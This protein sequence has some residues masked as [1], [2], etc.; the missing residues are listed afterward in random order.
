ME[1]KVTPVKL[2]EQECYNLVRLKYRVGARPK[3]VPMALRSSIC[4]TVIQRLHHPGVDLSLFNKNQLILEA[5]SR[6]SPS[7]VAAR[8][9]VLAKD[10]EEALVK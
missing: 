1:D 7:S 9:P 10:G 2:V 4:H 3:G 6:S 8:C 5:S